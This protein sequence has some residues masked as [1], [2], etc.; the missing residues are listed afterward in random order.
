MKSTNI[1]S[2]RNFIKAGLTVAGAGIVGGPAVSAADCDPQTIS[3]PGPIPLNNILTSYQDANKK[4]GQGL[5]K[6][7]V[8]DKSGWEGKRASILRR[9]KMMLGQAPIISGDPVTPE[10]LNEVQ[11]EGYKELKVR[12]P[13]GTGDIITGYL[14]VPAQTS[15]ASPRP[16]IM[17]LH[18]TGPGATQTVGLTPAENR[19]YGKELAERGYVVLAIDTITAGERVYPGYEQ[20]YTNEFYREFPNWSAMAKMIHDHQKGLDYLCSLDFVDPQRVGCIGHSLGGYNSFFLQAFDARIKAAVSSCGFTTMGA[21]NS[22]YQLARSDWFIHFN[23]QC[24]DYIEA[25]MIPCDMHEFM[26]LCAPRPLFNYSGK[27]DAIYY[28]NTARKDRGFEE[29]WQTVDAALGQVSS[30]YNILGMSDRFV[31]VETDGGHDFPADV[32]EQAYLWLDK[33]L[34]R[35]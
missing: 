9:A 1:S 24:R 18:P 27:K 33:W 8:C 12:F 31:R 16:A 2:R 20:Y 19:S 14:L 17:A 29:W 23:P 34:D 4:F 21:S 3:A 6:V 32:R 7:T 25:A 10:I 30:I 26:A 22:P 28:P 11:R 35:K 15:A 13:S 5:I